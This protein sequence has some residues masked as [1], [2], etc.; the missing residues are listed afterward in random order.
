MS[1][2][3]ALF[4]GSSS[5]GLKIAHAIRNDL[6][7]RE[8][9]HVRLWDEGIFRLS[10]SVPDSL[11][12]TA[13]G[14]DFAVLVFSPDD[15]VISRDVEKRGP[16]DNVVFELGLF[17][18]HLGR[19]RTFIV[20]REHDKIKLPSDFAGVTY[21]SYSTQID[22]SGHEM[23]N[24][25]TACDQI[26]EA[27]ERL[28]R[29]RHPILEQ[30]LYSIVSN[31]RKAFRVDHDVF[32]HHL[33]R[34]AKDTKA[35]SEVWGEGLLR[36]SLDYGLFLADVYRR[37]EESIFST[38]VPT[39]SSKVWKQALHPLDLGRVLLKAQQANVKAHSMRIFVYS[40]EQAIAADDIKIMRMHQEHKV[41]VY[42][43]VNSIYP[44]FDYNPANIESD[45]TMIDDGRAIGVT[46]S[47]D[48]Q[49]REAYWYFNNEGMA[50]DYK[51]LRDN[52]LD[53][54]VPLGD[55]LISQKA[56]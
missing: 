19:E 54:A 30:T 15:I 29:L 8:R 22:D 14:Y 38:T 48:S 16:R 1:V 24:V 51:R 36:I 23:P 39:Y 20:V 50:R 6:Q 13:A 5:E 56:G 18:G 7:R 31:Y 46:K 4:I 33:E 32:Q 9:V 27:V 12:R 35:E 34:W 53:L 2:Y 44:G 10:E 43:Y 17:A 26:M 41:E 21:A 42:V 47:I 49:R 52:L 11:V 28:G 55:W 40:D 45:W 25:G 3:P 37:A